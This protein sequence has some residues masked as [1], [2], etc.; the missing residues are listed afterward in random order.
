MLMIMIELVLAELLSHWIVYLASI[1]IV[2]ILSTS[3][4]FLLLVFLY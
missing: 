1:S 4:I 2:K 3:I